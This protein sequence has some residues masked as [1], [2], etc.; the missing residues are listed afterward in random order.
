MLEMWTSAVMIVALYGNRTIHLEFACVNHQ[1]HIYNTTLLSWAPTITA[2][3]SIAYRNA[4]QRSVRPALCV[5]AALR[6]R[7]MSCARL[8]LGG[9]Q[10]LFHFADQGIQG[11]A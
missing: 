3:A 10:L 5:S 2:I 1:L 6:V 9:W 11:L 8:V 4:G 7:F